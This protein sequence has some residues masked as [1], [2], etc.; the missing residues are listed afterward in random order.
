[1]E[2]FISLIIFIISFFSCFLLTNIWIKLAK[3]NNLVGKDMNKFDKP[4]IPEA[5]GIAVVSS[6]ILCILIYIFLKVFIF[7]TQ[8]HLI[9]VLTLIIT[10]LLA[11][12]I[13]FV[14]DILGWKKGL[15]GWKKILFTIPIAIPLAVINAGHSIINIPFFGNINFGL[16]YP[17]I[18]IPLAII[19]TTNAYN[20]LAGYNG[21]EAGLGIIIFIVYGII[22]LKTN[23]FWLALIA[24]III[25][26]LI[27]FLIFNFYPAKVFPGDSLTLPLGSLVGIFSILGNMER[28]GIILFIPFIIEGILKARSNFKAENFGL[29]QKDNTLKMPYKK[30]YS[31][32]HLSLF[33]LNKFKKPREIDVVIS[34]YI[35]EIIFAIIALLI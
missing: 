4:L 7:K 23:Q 6:I 31:L 12:F 3:K 22:A 1:M 32:T 8:T 33:L 30:I 19:V 5:G 11:C 25:F 35:F 21:L 26:S 34:I 18:L 9:E 14:D 13:G 15:G 24:G 27:A 29:P 17:L 28:I 2:I 20:M 10:L 16:I